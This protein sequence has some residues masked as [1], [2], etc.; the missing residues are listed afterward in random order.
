MEQVQDL[1]H[2]SSIILAREKD[3]RIYDSS[4][5]YGALEESFCKKT[6]AD[7]R[8]SHKSCL[9][10]QAIEQNRRGDTP[11]TDE[12]VTQFWNGY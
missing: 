2:R 12:A 11:E 10:R 3:S 5:N 8:A 4:V 6:T 1:H 9:L 7:Q